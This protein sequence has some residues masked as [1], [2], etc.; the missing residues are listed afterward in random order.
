MVCTKLTGE[1][2]SELDEIAMLAKK[3]RSALIRELLLKGLKLKRRELTKGG[4]K[5]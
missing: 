2:S 4:R 3:S 5:S 1:E